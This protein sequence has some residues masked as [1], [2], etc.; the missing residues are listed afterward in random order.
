[1]V[2]EKNI[3]D[4]DNVLA[5]VSSEDVHRALLVL[6]LRDIMMHDTTLSMNRIILHIKNEYDIPISKTNV[7]DILTDA[8]HL[9]SKV[10]EESMKL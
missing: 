1:M 5:D 2:R 9:I 3:Y 6:S 4:D 7:S 10:R 8:K